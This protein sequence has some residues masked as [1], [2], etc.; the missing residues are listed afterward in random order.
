MHTCMYSCTQACISIAAVQPAGPSDRQTVM[1]AGGYCCTAR[2][3][4]SQ[5]Q[6]GGPALRLCGAALNVAR[7]AMWSGAGGAGRVL[8]LRLLTGST[9]SS[10]ENT[11]GCRQTCRTRSAGPAA[12]Q[13]VVRSSCDSRNTSALCRER[14][15]RYVFYVGIPVLTCGHWTSGPGRKKPADASE[16]G[17][18]STRDR[19]ERR[20]GPPGL[21][22]TE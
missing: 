10:G 2:V 17:R 16:K 7:S 18:A 19:N 20:L 12:R 11:P 1:P 15:L 13:P 8:R 14:V 6:P 3:G 5:G 9:V 4:S 22:H 21:R